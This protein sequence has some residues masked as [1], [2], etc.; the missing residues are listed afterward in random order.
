MVVG[1]RPLPD[2]FRAEVLRMGPAVL[3]AVTGELDV[4]TTAEFRASVE[5]LDD[6]EAP[7]H[8]TVDLS[9]LDFIDAAGIAALL[10]LRNTIDDAGGSIRVR[11]AKPH[12][13]RVLE[14]A[15]VIDLLDA[16]SSS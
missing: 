11:S 3:L 5:G 10:A 8:V 9:R 6:P 4:A 13:R 2:A 15:G 7:A 14:L 16:G 1:S 12:V